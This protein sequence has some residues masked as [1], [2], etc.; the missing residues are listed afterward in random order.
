M[1]V[2]VRREE[3]RVPT[4]TAKRYCHR[5]E[6]HSPMLTLTLS[7]LPLLCARSLSK[8]CLCLAHCRDSPFLCCLRAICREC[9]LDV[10]V[11]PVVFATAC[12]ESARSSLFYAAGGLYHCIRCSCSG[13]RSRVVSTLCCVKSHSPPIE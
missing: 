13:I 12:A 1:C 7:M 8:R 3:M 5:G 11:W 6:V 4:F 2:S 9:T 10:S